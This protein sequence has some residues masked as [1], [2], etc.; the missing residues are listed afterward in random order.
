MNRWAHGG[1]RRTFQ[2]GSTPYAL[3]NRGIAPRELQRFDEA[4]NVHQQDLEIC[5]ETGDRHSEA[6]AWKNLGLALWELRQFREAR[7][8]LREAAAAYTETGDSAAAQAVD[9]DLS[10]PT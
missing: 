5:R 9:A 7:R 6:K 1:I 3:N 8:C 2:G 10:R 4:I